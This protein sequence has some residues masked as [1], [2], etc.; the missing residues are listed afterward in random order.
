MR[1]DERAW[2]APFQVIEEHPLKDTNWV[3]FKLE[4]KNTGKTPA[5][6]ISEWHKTAT[7]LGEVAISKAPELPS[8]TNSMMLAPDGVSFI[9]VETVGYGAS[10][11]IHNGM[12]VFIYGRIIYEDIFGNRHWTDFC[13][14]CD[15]LLNWKPAAIR[16]SCDDAKNTSTQNK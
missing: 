14:V 8:T 6:N 12:P 3:V 15:S 2:V 10:N 7:S 4:F 9:K 1:L 11:A 5:L 16:N 13:W